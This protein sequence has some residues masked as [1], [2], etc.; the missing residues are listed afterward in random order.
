MS[1]F[2]LTNIQNDLT[3]QNNFYSSLIPKDKKEETILF[4]AIN[5]PDYKISDFINTEIVVQDV[6]CEMVQCTNK[7]TGEVSSVPRI[8]LITPDNETYQA[9]S[10][11]IYNSMKKVFAIKGLPETWAEPIKIKIQQVTRGERKMLTFVLV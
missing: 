9:V 10:I 6:I 3:E 8:I 2:A 7:E 11:G 4:N 1:E 5:N